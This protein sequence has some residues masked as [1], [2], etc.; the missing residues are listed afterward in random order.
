MAV[1]TAGAGSFAGM[2]DY[3]VLAYAARCLR[4]ATASG[5]DRMPAPGEMAKFNQAMTEFNRRRLRAMDAAFLAAEAG[6]RAGRV[7]QGS[8]QA[9]RGE[10]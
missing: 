6:E 7:P 9:M 1:V 8:S 4:M 10:G 2:Q 5:P 3:E